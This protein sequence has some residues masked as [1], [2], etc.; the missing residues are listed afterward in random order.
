MSLK[1]FHSFP[2]VNYDIKGDNVFNNITDITRRT[3]IRD[4]LDEFVSAYYQRS[5]NGQRPEVMSHEE[6]NDVRS[7]WI[8][9]HLNSIEDPYFEWCMDEQSL[10][11]YIDKKYV[12]RVY[13]LEKDHF[14]KDNKSQ[15]WFFYSGETITDINSSASPKPY[16]TCVN[17]DTDLLQVTYK[18]IVGSDQVGGGFD[19]TPSGIAI[20]QGGDNRPVGEGNYG[21]VDE[22]GDTIGRN[23]VHHYED[24]NENIISRGDY[25]IDQAKAVELRVGH[26]KITNAEYEIALNDA[27]REINV[28]DPSLVDQLEKEFLEKINV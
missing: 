12:N 2:K 14:S 1:Y 8:L 23:A 18:N 26:I 16:A 19:D 20:I 24:S 25:E 27:R 15:Y 3:K 11:R 22:G 13:R 21:I 7:H 10:Q 5:S 9:L 28:L 17:F 6:Y 4:T